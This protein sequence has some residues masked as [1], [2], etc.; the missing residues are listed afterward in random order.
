MNISFVVVLFAQSTLIAS[1]SKMH[2]LA[3]IMLLLF[4]LFFFFSNKLFVKEYYFHFWSSFI[5]GG[6]GMKL[7]CMIDM[8]YTANGISNAMS[9]SLTASFINY[10][11]LFMIASCLV[12]CI[13]VPGCRIKQKSLIGSAAGYVFIMFSMLVGMY[14]GKAISIELHFE[15]FYRARLYSQCLF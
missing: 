11:T 5:F 3:Y 6:L 4:W 14:L 13:L 2:I 12:S 15:M 10:M 9:L 8:H 7:G 1:I